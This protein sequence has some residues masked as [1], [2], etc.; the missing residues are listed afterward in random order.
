[1]ENIHAFTVYDN[2]VLSRLH[3][4]IISHIGSSKNTISGRLTVEYHHDTSEN[5]IS[6]RLRISSRYDLEYNLCAS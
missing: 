1:M 5:I 6:V 2:S 3:N 4:I